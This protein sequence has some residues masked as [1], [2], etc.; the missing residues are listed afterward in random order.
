MPP[1]TAYLA[2]FNYL[3]CQFN[4]VSNLIQAQQNPLQ[5]R[6]LLHDFYYTGGWSPTNV[7][8]DA[9]VLRVNC[10]HFF[11]FILI[12]QGNSRLL[13]SQ[14]ERVLTLLTYFLN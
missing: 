3:Y 4:A 2:R 12:K 7:G 8:K 10:T 1:F 9:P 5:G 13:Q 14:K 6:I 11:R